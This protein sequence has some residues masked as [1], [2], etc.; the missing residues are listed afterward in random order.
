MALNLS[1]LATVLSQKTNIES[2]IILE[3]DGI[4]AVYGAVD[5]TKLA[6][7]GDAIKFGDA[8]LVYGGVVAHPDSKP[9]ISPKGSTRNITQQLHQDKGGTGSV[10]S[11]K[12]K[13]VDKNNEVSAA[14]AGIE[15]L[16]RSADVYVAFQGGSH[17]QDS[18]KIFNG[19]IDDIGYGSGNVTIKIAH[20]EQLK[21]QTIFPLI[22][23]DLSI[24]LNSTDTSCTVL[25]TSGMIPSN[26]ANVISYVRIN[27]EIIKYT[28]VTATTI[29]GMIR[30]Q[31][32]TAATAHDLGDSV[33]TV[34]NITDAPLD[35]ALRLMLSGRGYDG[36]YQILS[37]DSNKI[38]VKKDPELQL[39]LIVGDF[40]ETTGSAVGGNNQTGVTIT[41][42]GV[43][44]GNYH[45][46]T[47]A[48]FT[49]EVSTTAVL[50]TKS[51][52]DTY[53]DGCALAPNFVDVEEHLSLDQLIGSSLPDLDFLLDDTVKAKEFIENEVYFPVGFYQIPRKGKSSLGTTLPPLADLNTKTIDNSNI[54]NAGNIKTSR[55]TNKNFY[56]AVVYKYNKN[57]VRDKFLNGNLTLSTRS[58]AKIKVGNKP[59]EIESNGLKNTGAVTNFIEAQAR[60]FID[61]YQFNA[62]SFE[63]EVNYK[64]GF[65]IDIGDTAL[66]NANGLGIVDST[67]G[68]TDFNTRIMEVTNK[69]MNITSGMVK[70][71]L[72]DTAF[73]LDGNY[74]VFSGSSEIVSA[75][76]TSIIIKDSFSTPAGKKERYKWDGFEGELIRVHNADYTYDE[77]IKFLGFAAGN[78]YEMLIDTL[79]I[80]PSAGFIIDIPEHSGDIS[81]KDLYKKIFSFTMTSVAVVSGTTTTFDVAI[82][83]VDKFF[84][85]SVISL[86]NTDFTS[87]TEEFEVND[88]TGTTITIDGDFGLTPTSSYFV[89]LIGFSSDESAPQRYL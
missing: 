43:T 9:Y 63:V 58:T 7:Y 26:T 62:E 86:R 74:G 56:N 22:Q 66:F 85:G 89:E 1:T 12:I 16:S 51:Q 88:I 65:N 68:T 23:T 25:N 33:E 42:F 29:T 84:I 78:D 18:V 32:G 35:M 28:G 72:T 19:T 76:T 24:A 46:E 27:D 10:S 15:V 60:R 80:A 44:T 59:L 77:E 67:T 70:I 17:P 83:D 69:S 53:P 2:Q 5:V 41:G 14:F 20:P 61:R 45:I 48:T 50:N 40:V 49:A 3:I 52:Y 57:I 6:E 75:T 87:I 21:R 55:S 73:S 39:G 64:T 11:V 13:L 8:E 38:I 34:Y 79:A 54:T 82:G 71:Q 31:F 30:G 36:A 81:V 37:F 47:D 4:D